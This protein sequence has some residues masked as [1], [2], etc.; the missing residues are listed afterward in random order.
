MGSDKHKDQ[1]LSKIQQWL[2]EDKLHH[3]ARIDQITY[4]E[5]ELAS[6][7]TRLTPAGTNEVISSEQEKIMVANGRRSGAEESAELM[8]DDYDVI[9]DLTVDTL[10]VRIY[11]ESHSDLLTFELEDLTNVGPHRIKLLTYMLEHPGRYVSVENAAICHGDP[12]EKR[13]PATLRT[14]IKFLRQTLGTPGPNNPYIKT[15]RSTS[16]C[17]YALNHRWS[18]L[19]IKWKE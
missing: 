12:D 3:Q 6:M 17:A 1:I 14:T 13:V 19:L 7:T 8:I 11:P 16:P 9:L 15:K 5:H 4:L 18:Y 2:A 10:Q